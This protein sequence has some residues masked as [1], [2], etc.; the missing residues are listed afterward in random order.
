MSSSEK[1][2]PRLLQEISRLEA[3]GQPDVR[4]PVIIRHAVDLGPL[5]M[6]GRAPR[7]KT[8]QERAEADRRDLLDRLRRMT[9]G[10]ELQR[11][12]MANAIETRLTAG[13]IR[14]IAAHPD[15]KQ[16]IWN[17]EERVTA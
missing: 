11:L 17:R 8:G 13:Q 16:I 12:E 4:V 7:D 9:E 14:E 5:G 3:G 1:I 2:E 6:G 10:E 15:V